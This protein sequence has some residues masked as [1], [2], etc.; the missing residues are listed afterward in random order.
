MAIKMQKVALLDVFHHTAKTKFIEKLADMFDRFKQS[1]KLFE[2][3]YCDTTRFHKNRPYKTSKQAK[4]SDI[5]SRRFGDSMTPL[6][7]VEMRLKLTMR[8]Q[9]LQLI[10]IVEVVTQIL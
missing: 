6:S 10:Y 4:I 5:I 9:E 8:V 1:Y 7:R 3:G 2:W